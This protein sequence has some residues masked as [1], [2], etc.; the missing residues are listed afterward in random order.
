MNGVVNLSKRGLAWGLSLTAGSL[1][2]A[3]SGCGPQKVAVAPPPPPQ[4]V[5]IPPRPMPP[6][7]AQ[8]NMP[9]P[10]L[11]A[12]G[13]RAT[14]NSGISPAQALWNLRS[15]YNVAA[16][17]CMGPDHGPILAGYKD[18]LIRHAKSLT[19]T[20][21]ALDKEYVTRYGA[22]MGAKTRETYQTQ[23]YNFFALPPVVPAL[24][25]TMIGLAAELQTVPANQLD[26]VAAADLAKAEAPYMEFFNSYDQYRA[27]LAAWESR[28]GA[29]SAAPQ[30][31]APVP[32][33]P[34]ASVPANKSQQQA[35]A[36]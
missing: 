17:N 14:V 31:A 30:L 3:L 12:N 19:A 21:K 13:M 6:A 16:L 26:S 34:V 32:T 20:N 4:A 27:D 22:K 35:F 1:A 15:A 18:F 33:T 2:V 36:Q 5:V 29:G 23:V 24:C 11:A 10:A 9:I 25:N 7:G 28:Y 8:N